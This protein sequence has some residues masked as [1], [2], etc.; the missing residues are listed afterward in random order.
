MRSKTNAKK[1]FIIIIIIMVLV[2]IMASQYDVMEH[3]VLFADKHEQF[4]LDE[5]VPVFV[6]LVFALA[7]FSIRRWQEVA[8]SKRALLQ[9]NT[10][11]QQALSDIKQLKGLIPICA[12]CKNIRD[13]KGYWHQ[14]EVYIQTHTDAD[15]THGIC[16][17]CIKKHYPDI[18]MDDVNRDG[19]PS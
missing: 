3:L 6:F 13:D 8:Q 2:Y 18:D 16:P 5:I 7:L 14:I 10:E 1:E 4:Q 15:F 11:L 19:N 17:D 12:A 9:S